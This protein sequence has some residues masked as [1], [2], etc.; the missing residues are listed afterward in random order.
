[1]LRSAGAPRLTSG[2]VSQTTGYT[3]MFGWHEWLREVKTNV[4]RTSSR[5][6]SGG[7]ALRT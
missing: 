6:V 2:I 3:R 4:S 5:T 1:M 7:R